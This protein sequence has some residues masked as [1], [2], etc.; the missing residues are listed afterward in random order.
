MACRIRCGTSEMQ[1][2]YRK[3]GRSSGARRALGALLLVGL[4]GWAAPASALDETT[5][6]TL[7]KM[8]AD[9]VAA[10]QAEDYK[11]AVEKLNKA[12][13]ILQTAPLGLWSGR[14]LEKSGRLVEASERYLA[15]ERAA[16]DPGGDKA[17]QEAA[18]VEAREAYQAIRER[19]PMLTVEVEGAESSEVTLTIGGRSILADFVGAPVAVDPGEVEVVGTLGEQVKKLSVRI[20]EGERKSV[21][22]TFAPGEGG[23]ATTTTTT[24]AQAHEPEADEQRTSG[25][26]PSWQ[27]IAGW[28]GI[29]LGG[30]GLILGG[31]TGGIV[32]SKWSELGCDSATQVC[33]ADDDEVARLNT[34]RTV[35]TI[36]FIAGGVLA[37]AGVTLLVTAPKKETSVAIRPYFTGDSV[38]FTGSF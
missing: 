6:S 12:W 35:S 36:G 29:G 23:A 5:R 38:G 34:L 22:L 21:K 1:T 8:S 18:R 10:Y 3:R 20:D 30:A 37:A 17:A 16:L 25:G 9:G 14:A 2:G 19:V 15:A 26:G 28:S 13:G 24:G 11:T 4:N 32:M 31:V 27:R 33:N 7:R